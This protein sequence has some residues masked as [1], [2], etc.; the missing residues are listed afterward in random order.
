MKSWAQKAD[1]VVS[2]FSAVDKRWTTKDYP[3]KCNG[4]LMKVTLFKSKKMITESV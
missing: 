4:K 1:N 2:T 3:L